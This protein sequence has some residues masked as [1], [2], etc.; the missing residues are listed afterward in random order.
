MNYTD[1]DGIINFVLKRENVSCVCSFCFFHVICLCW[2]TVGLKGPFF[3]LES[4]LFSVH[5][6]IN[7]EEGLS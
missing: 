1:D 7:A 5:V 3:L 4:C 2:P 6:C